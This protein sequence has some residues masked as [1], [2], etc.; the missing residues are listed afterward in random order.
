MT[1]PSILPPGD[2][3]TQLN[4]DRRRRDLARLRSSSPWD[5]LVVGGGI[6]GVGVALDAAARGLEVALVEKHDFAFGT[7]RWSSKLVHGGL[8]YLAKGDVGVAWE[9]AVE[10]ATIGNRIAPHLLHKMPQVVPVYDGDTTTAML[11]RASFLAADMLRMAARTKR[12]TLDSGEFV[13]TEAALRL[14]PTLKRE[15]LRGAVV[16]NELQLEDDARLVTALARTAAGYGA[17]ILIGVEALELGPHSRLRVTDTGEVIDVTATHVINATG[18]WAGSLD[19]T[20]TLQPSRGTHLVVP[21]AALGW[22]TGSLTV[23]VPDHFGRFVFTLPQP[24]GLTYIG[25]TDEPVEGPVPDVPEAPD[26]DIQWILGVINTVLD[27]PLTSSDVVGTFAGLRPLLA[28]PGTGA[29]EPSTGDGGAA[30]QG[31]AEQRTHTADLSRRHAIVRHDNVISVTGGKLT[32]YRRMAQDVV[33]LIT[34]RPCRTTDIAAV[35]A[36]SVPP[37]DQIPARLVRRYG[38]EAALV[39]SFGDEDPALREPVAAG[40]PVLGVEMAF[41]VVWEGASRVED[42]LERRTRLSMSPEQAEAARPAATRILR[43]FAPVHVGT[44]GPRRESVGQTLGL[45][46][47]TG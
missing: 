23:Q 35:G 25:L 26:G 20:I 13:G 30:D 15:G 2:P 43:D 17:R 40:L 7:S 47:T 34:T 38:S 42:L 44:L 36:G 37:D 33:D 12:G 31:E 46:V 18:V 9:S 28:P 32:A 27:T 16:S 21:S 41:A 22:A 29:S 14:A 10:R 5:V 24:D 39:W 3:A 11:V 6:T 19:P 4:Q 8:R 45:P 1:E